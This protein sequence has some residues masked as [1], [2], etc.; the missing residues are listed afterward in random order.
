MDNVSFL[1]DDEAM[2]VLLFKEQ[3]AERPCRHFT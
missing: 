3:L 2:L 1:E